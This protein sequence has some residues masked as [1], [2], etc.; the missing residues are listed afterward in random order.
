HCSS[1]CG[2]RSASAAADGRWWGCRSG[3]T[4]RDR[5]PGTVV[6]RIGLPARAD[7]DPFDVVARAVAADEAPGELDRNAVGAEG[8]A[9]DL[10]RRRP[11]SLAEETGLAGSQ[12]DRLEGLARPHDPGPVA[13]RQQVIERAVLEIGGQQAR[14]TL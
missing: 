7:H 1:S 12:Q 14:E 3:T 2:F 5:R 8:D 11:R 10:E 6:A 13:R 4:G 9:L